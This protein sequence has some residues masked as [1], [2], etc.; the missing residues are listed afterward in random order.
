MQL[1]EP[2]KR[3]RIPEEIAS[4]IRSLIE[5]GTYEADKPLPP[6]RVL[7]QRFDVSRGSVRDA[8][9]MLEMIGLLET[10]H[11]QGTYPRELDV[12]KLVTPLASVLS[13]NSRLQDE[14]LDVRRM[15][16]PAVARVAASRITAD[17]LEELDRI[18]A[19]QRARLRGGDTTIDD[20]TE[21]HAAIARATH[22]RVVEHIMQTLN[23][24]LVT[25]RT[26]TLKQPGRQ[27]R[28]IRGHASV[29]AALREGDSDGAAVA[30]TRHI[31]QIGE[32]M[33]QA[34]GQSS[35]PTPPKR[36]ARGS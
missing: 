3:T 33:R 1:I 8:L 25:S 35:Q 26:Q 5:D 34:S 10:R 32:L 29:V 28:S 4:R 9:R 24:L 20:D 13:F 19:S 7:A 30:M 23:E 17:E 21:F 6:E 27:Q 18:L 12:E 2:I 11:G 36:D 22:N 14:L 15:F 31:E 16:E